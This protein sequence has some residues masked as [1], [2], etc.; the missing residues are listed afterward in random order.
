MFLQLRA[1][2]QDVDRINQQIVRVL[3]ALEIENGAKYSVFVDFLKWDLRLITLPS[4][5]F[6]SHHV[7]RPNK[8]VLDRIAAPGAGDICRQGTSS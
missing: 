7:T 4:F 5:I 3:K 8:L 1:N 6:D 2:S